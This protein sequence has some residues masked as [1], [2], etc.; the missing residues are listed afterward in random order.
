MWAPS[1]R[2]TKNG[3]PPT[4]RNARTG[5]LTPP[6]MRRWARSKSWSEP[7]MRSG[8]LE[9]GRH[10]VARAGIPD[11]GGRVDHP[12]LHHREHHVHRVRVRRLS[13]D[14]RVL[15]V[16]GREV[17]AGVDVGVVDGGDPIA[18]PLAPADG[19]Q[20][21]RVDEVGGPGVARM[22]LRILV[23]ELVLDVAARYEDPVARR[24][25]PHQQDPAALRRV[26]GHRLRVDPG[27]LVAGEDHPARAG[28]PPAGAGPPPAR[29]GMIE[30]SSPSFSVV[31]S[32]CS[33]SIAS[34]F[35]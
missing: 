12:S 7:V 6:G 19:E 27:E 9:L 16:G 31:S 17:G 20:I 25:V 35:T 18:L 34:L 15:A 30:T 29:A 26:L 11:E 28:P 21:L 3:V 5:L 2:A 23:V 8:L 1:A 13:I 32:P 14:E 10:E 33:A 24:C 22:P 4:P